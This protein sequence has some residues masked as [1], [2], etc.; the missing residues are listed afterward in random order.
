MTA[1]FELVNDQTAAVRVYN[2]KDFDPASVLSKRFRKHAD[3]VRYFLHTIH[4]QRFMYRRTA[5][6]FIEIKASYMM[7]FFSDKRDYKPVIEELK[8][9]EVLECDGHYVQGRKSFGYRL[10]PRWRNVPFQSVRVRNPLLVRKMLAKRAELRERVQTDVHL[11]LRAWVERLDFNYAAAVQAADHSGTS[12]Y[13]P[14]LEMLRDKDLFFSSCAYGRV[15]HNVSSLKTEYR[16]FLSYNAQELINLDVANSQPLLFSVVLINYLLNDGYLSSMY[17]CDIDYSGLYI[18]LPTSIFLQEGNAAQQTQP[19]HPLRLPKLITTDERTLNSDQRLIATDCKDTTR[20]L[21]SR[22]L[23][24]DAL[25]YVELTQRGQLYEYLMQ[26]EGI[27]SSKR[28]EFKKTFFG[29][30][31]FCQNRPVTKQAKLFQKHFP[32]AYKVIFDL[33]SNDYRRLA[34]ILQ[35]TESS[36]IINRIVRSCMLELPEVCVVT[37]HDSIMTTPDAVDQVERIMA[38]EFGRVGVDPCIR[39]ERYADI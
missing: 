33:K 23:P 31:F 4:H 37:I 30:V 12:D 14:M 22:G 18:D 5:E 6:D 34:H 13:L 15:H 27:P 19:E 11:Y 32:S 36:L 7:P 1:G 39:R 35:R 9:K 3:S 21:M 24:Q 2:P 16:R 26:Q 10:G 38:Q 29:S 17:S 28:Q 8:A 25:L 20:R